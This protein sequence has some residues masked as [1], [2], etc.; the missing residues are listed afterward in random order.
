MGSQLQ[1][2]TQPSF[3]DLAD[4]TLAANTVLTDTSLQAISRNAKFGVVRCEIVYQGF[5]K[6]LDGIALPV[7]PVDAYVYTAA[8]VQYD[9]ELYTTRGPGTGFA[10][11]QVQAP[12][13]AAGQSGNL[14]WWTADIDATA[15][16]RLAMA[17]A[18]GTTAVG[19][20]LLKVYA[21]GQ[22]S[23][24]LAMAAIPP[25]LDIPDDI[26]AVA[27]PLREG[28]ALGSYGITDL[29]HNAKFAC[30][31]KEIIPLGFWAMGYTVLPPVSPVDG[32]AYAVSEVIFR[33]IPYSN[34]T[35]AGSFSN[36][37]AGAPTLGNGQLARDGAGHGPIYWWMM[38]IDARGHT[39][40]YISYYVQ[41]GAETIRTNSGIV[42]VFAICQ[43]GSVNS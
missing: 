35:P 1:I 38:D 29:S 13:I 5:Y 15:T 14:F 43:R 8:E 34:L 10:S 2:S 12:P 21:M 27:Q 26:L 28:N 37:Q 6:H 17:Y 9:F 24:A 30:V 4:S 16:V 36:G 33:G 42:K 23:A 3:N 11:G 41:G 25:F 22:R 7:S 40:S 18:D 32:Y 31:R 19:D 20:G 39:S